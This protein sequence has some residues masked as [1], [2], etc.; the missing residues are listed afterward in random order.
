MALGTFFMKA[1]EPERH[2]AELRAAKVG[3]DLAAWIFNLARNLM[4]LGALKYFSDKT[5]DVYVQIAYH[6]CTTALV[7]YVFTYWQTT[8]LR[9]LTLY[10]RN[11]YAELADLALNIFIGVAIFIGSLKIASTMADALAR[12]QGH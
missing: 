12:D 1:F 5:N 10:T 2:S 7:I 9:V 4:L 8:Y 6:V 3:R 11:V